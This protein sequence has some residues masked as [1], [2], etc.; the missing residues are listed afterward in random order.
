MPQHPAITRPGL[1]LGT[2]FSMFIHSQVPTNHSPGALV[3]PGLG[4]LEIGQAR[5]PLFVSLG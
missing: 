1:M 2:G 3:G 5:R 4:G